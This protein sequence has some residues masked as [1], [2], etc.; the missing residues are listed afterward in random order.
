MVVSTS[1]GGFVSD[2]E[3]FV[4]TA[5]PFFSWLRESQTSARHHEL[6]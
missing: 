6:K 5:Y 2:T 4:M 3:R 1:I